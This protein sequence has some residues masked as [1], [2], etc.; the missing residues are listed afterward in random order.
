MKGHSTPSSENGGSS[1][2]GDPKAGLED[3]NR[4]ATLP[5]GSS[6]MKQEAPQEAAQTTAEKAKS[7]IA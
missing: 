7:V 4:L 2:C 1:T 3:A 5:L 6:K